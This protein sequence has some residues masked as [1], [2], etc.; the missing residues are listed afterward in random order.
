MPGFMFW[1]TAAGVLGVL[2]WWLAVGCLN[3]GCAGGHPRVTVQGL[4]TKDRCAET[5]SSRWKGQSGLFGGGA[6]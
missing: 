3:S 6:A 5:H 2:D 4:W 1:H